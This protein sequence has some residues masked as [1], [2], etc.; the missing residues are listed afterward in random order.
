M[1]GNDDYNDD[2]DDDGV[3]NDNFY[4]IP[5]RRQIQRCRRHEREAIERQRFRRRRC[6][7][8]TD[9]GGERGGF[10]DSRRV[11]FASGAVKTRLPRLHL[12][13]LQGTALQWGRRWRRWRL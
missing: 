10:F 7:S 6:Y 8:G 3:D 5:T 11:F 9:A 2:N 12:S 1:F 13:C 4:F